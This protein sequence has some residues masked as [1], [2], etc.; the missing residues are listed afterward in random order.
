MGNIKTLQR[1]RHTV[2]GTGSMTIIPIDKLSLTYTGNQL[3]K[4]MDTSDPGEGFVKPTGRVPA[5]EYIYNKNGS[6]TTDFNRSITNICYNVLNLPDTITFSGGH[7]TQYSYDASG[8]KRRVVHRTV[9]ATVQSP[10]STGSRPLVAV[11]TTRTDYCGNVIYENGVLKYILTPEGYVSRSGRSTFVYN[12]YLKDHLGNNRVV[13]AVNGTNYTAEQRT[14]YYPFGMPFENGLAPEKQPYKFGGKELDEMHGLNTYD[15]G[16]G[17]TIRVGD[18]GHA[19]NGSTG[20][21]VL[22]YKPVCAV[23]EQPR[24]CS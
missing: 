12:Y 1:S 9:Q 24:K 14:D 19:D 17:K 3:M 15:Q 20:G 5:I 21:K 2:S 10:G 11:D 6:L 8:T 23:F 22:Q 13:M 4:I 16:G 7:S 18:S